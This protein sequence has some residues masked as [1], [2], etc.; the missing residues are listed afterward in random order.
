M[1]ISKLWRVVGASAA[2]VLLSFTVASPAAAA[3]YT[4]HTDDDN[5]GGRVEF[6]AY[7]D[8]VKLCDI[9]KDGYQATISIY[10]V[11]AAQGQYFDFVGGVGNCIT[12][13]ASQGGYY[14][15]PEDHVFDFEICLYDGA[16]YRFCDTSRWSN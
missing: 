14:N 1:N 10:D 12:H 3:D 11:S 13:D 15:L 2:T 4:M 16:W 7:G 8:V 9:Q 5:P 6:T